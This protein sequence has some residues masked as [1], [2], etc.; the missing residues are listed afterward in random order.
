MKPSNLSIYLSDAYTRKVTTP[1]HSTGGFPRGKATRRRAEGGR[2]IAGLGRVGSVLR[3]YTVIRVVGCV[4]VVFSG[5][6]LRGAC[7]E[8]RRV[9]RAHTKGIVFTQHL[10]VWVD[11]EYSFGFR[12]C[13][14]SAI[15]I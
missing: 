6:F 12:A 10:L 14:G 5:F 13:A 11:S 2:V 8:A 1:P 3:V 4:K 7:L 15:Y 9:G